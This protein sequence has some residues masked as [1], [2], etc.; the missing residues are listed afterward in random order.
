MKDEIESSRSALLLIDF[1]RDFLEDG[2][3]MP[4]A[5]GQ[6]PAVLEAAGRAIAAARAAGDLVVAIGNE[7]RPGDLLMN[8]LRR[9]AAMSGSEGARWTDKL[10]RDGLPYFPKWAGSAFV[11]P[12]L[13]PWLRARGVKTLALTGV[14]AKACVSATA[15]D[16]LARG[17]EVRVL[18]D[19]VGCFSDASRERAFARLRARGV[20]LARAA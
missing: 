17:Y 2:G 12:E 7:F 18:T 4:A 3:R 1:Q 11:N 20:E 6:V 14:M 19:A 16:A 9:G 10:P 5:R 15:K 13:D 8:L